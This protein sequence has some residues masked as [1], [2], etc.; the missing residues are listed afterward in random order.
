[1]YIAIDNEN[2][3]YFNYSNNI[4]TQRSDDTIKLLNLNSEMIKI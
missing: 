3:Y 4:L 1:M 2:N